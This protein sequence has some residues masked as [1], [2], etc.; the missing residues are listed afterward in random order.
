MTG[1]VFAAKVTFRSARFDPKGNSIEVTTFSPSAGIPLAH[2]NKTRIRAKSEL[3]K[4]H[5]NR[6]MTAQRNLSLP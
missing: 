2:R 1:E 5:G 6:K 3:F 4:Q